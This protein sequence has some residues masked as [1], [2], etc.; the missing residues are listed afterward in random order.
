MAKQ[1][2][3]YKLILC[4]I[5]LIGIGLCIFFGN[6]KQG[7]YLD[8]WYTVTP[9]NGN[10]LGIAIDVGQWNDTSPIMVQVS[11][12]DNE[13]F[14]YRR[15][16]DTVYGII[17]PPTYYMLY[18]TICSFFPNQYSKW[19][20]ISL[21]LFIY[22]LSIAAIYLIVSLL[23]DND[24]YATLIAVA[25]YAFS[26]AIIS[27]VMLNRDYFA[28]ALFCM[29]YAYI[30][31][32]DYKKSRHCELK[33]YIC[34]YII[35]LVGLFMDYMFLPIMLLLM[36]SYCVYLFFIQKEYLRTILYC[37]TELFMLISAYIL[38]HPIIKSFTSSKR[39]KDVA[40]NLKSTSFSSLS[41][42][43]SVFYTNL[44]KGVFGGLIIIAFIALIISIYFII[45]KRKYYFTLLKTKNDSQ[46][47]QFFGIVML[48]FTSLV[49]FLLMMKVG[50]L[51]SYAT[52]RFVFPVYGFMII[53]FSVVLVKILKKYTQ[54]SYIISSAI[55]LIMLLSAFY[56]KQVIYLYED[57][58]SI[59]EW[60]QNHPS[61]EPVVVQGD[62]AYDGRIQDYMKFDRVYFASTDDLNTLIDDEIISKKELLVYV[63]MKKDENLESIAKLFEINKNIETSEMIYEKAGTFNIY[64]LH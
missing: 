58:A 4:L 29:L 54:H 23:S 56:Q 30:I 11:V 3:K 59:G 6:K 34:T 31:L 9:A 28:M 41:K 40:N 50:L 17:H 24:S 55:I 14:S 25:F 61:V 13:R 22:I 49:Y 42:R 39:S 35:S 44:N 33:F 47:T 21:N 18:H 53:T 7:Y 19:F 1:S 8:E 36:F 27:G 52:N 63:D 60:I 15:V 64:Y 38:Y 37:I 51:S 57:E 2:K 16:Y 43:I 46:S 45:K 62:G 48:S 5:F 26:P 32:L 10:L 12:Q 20:G